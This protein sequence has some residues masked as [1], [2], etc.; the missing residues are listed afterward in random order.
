MPEQP[1]L[2]PP[3]LGRSELR[4]VRQLLARVRDADSE[5]GHITFPARAGAETTVEPPEMWEAR[6]AGT[7]TERHLARLRE[8]HE[9]LQES[10]RKVKQQA[11]SQ[12]RTI[13]EQ[14]R[15]IAELRAQLAE[16]TLDHA[17]AQVGGQVIVPVQREGDAGNPALHRVQVDRIEWDAMPITPPNAGPH[18]DVWRIYG[19]TVMT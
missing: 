10:H 12:Q 7:H 8:R 5:C 2:Q 6:R 3:A 16:P 17:L 14:A 13:S 9:E 15:E 4:A 11:K 19:H 1:H 18:R